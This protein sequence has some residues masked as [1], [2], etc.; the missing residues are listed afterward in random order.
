MRDELSIPLLF[1]ALAH[2]IVVLVFTVKAIFF[3]EAIE[4]YEQAIRV[5]LV[6]LPDKALPPPPLA[7]EPKK[8]EEQIKEP[9][10][11]KP[12]VV[13]TPELEK[14]APELVLTP[15]K[16][17]KKNKEDLK[18]TTNDA[19]EKLKKKI[20][21]EKIKDEIKTEVRKDLSDRMAKYKG[22]VLSPG[23]ELTG[24][25][26]LQH[27]NYQGDIDQHVKHYWSL[28]EWLA[29]GNYSAQVKI[30]LDEQG[31][32]LKVQMVKTSGNSSYDDIVIET[33]KK[34]V[35]YPPPPEKF[36]AVVSINGIVL[37]FPE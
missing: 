37:G 13:K 30:F 34:A 31:L 27:E 35:P 2:I 21:I 19:I 8:P 7:S 24:V 25:N 17:A 10:P 4:P 36:K 33:V 26:K 3:P 32:L 29:R 11:S 22:S 15:K 20:A 14:E 1:S 6:D 18:L 23:S 9:E 28:P 12:E 16:E 5:D